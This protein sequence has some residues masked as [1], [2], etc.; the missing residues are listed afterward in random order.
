MVYCPKYEFYFES[1]GY[2]LRSPGKRG[3]VTGV[4]GLLRWLPADAGA[5]W[6]ASALYSLEKLEEGESDG[7][8]A[9]FDKGKMVLGDWLW[10]HSDIL[11]GAELCT[12]RQYYGVWAQLPA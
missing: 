1:D 3:M 9:G 10:F 8:A 12:V 7:Q 6:C 5:V 11:Y 4:L 2:L